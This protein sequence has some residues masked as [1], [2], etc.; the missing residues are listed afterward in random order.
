MLQLV[1]PESKEQH[2][3]EIL[4]LLSPQ[5]PRNDNVL[6]ILNCKWTHTRGRLTKPILVFTE[7]MKNEVAYQNK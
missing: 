2:N 7:E 3:N 1:A 5:V 4:G 6:A